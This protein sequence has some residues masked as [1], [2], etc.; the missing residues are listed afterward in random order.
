MEGIV[1]FCQSNL[2][3]IYGLYGLAFFITGIA[4]A[5]ECGR[6]SQLA[7]AR[8]L[9]FLA[10]FGVAHGIHEWVEMFGLM[11]PETPATQVPFYIQL[12]NIIL[13]A[14]SFVCLIEFA[15]RLMRLLDP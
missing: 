11:V 14:G 4:V 15:L 7:L 3:L 8:A 2:P 13:L 9:P 6:A 1:N 12:T 5:L 10:A